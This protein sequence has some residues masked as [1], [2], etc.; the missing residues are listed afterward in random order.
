[1]AGTSRPASRRVSSSLKI[2]GDGVADRDVSA[3][4]LLAQGSSRNL[5]PRIPVP[6]RSVH[7]TRPRWTN[8]GTS[9]A[10]RREC[11]RSAKT[12]AREPRPTPNTIDATWLAAASWKSQC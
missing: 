7:W 10:I 6:A 11:M 12:T 5:Y 9:G 4:L 8:I 2:G 1:M 3:G